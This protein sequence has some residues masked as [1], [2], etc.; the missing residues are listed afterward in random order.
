MRFKERSVDFGFGGGALLF[1]HSND[2]RL[3][4]S[5]TKRGVTLIL[6]HNGHEITPH[7]NALRISRQIPLFAEI[8]PPEYWN[9]TNRLMRFTEHS[10]D[11][12]FEGGPLLFQHSND[13]HANISQTKRGVTLILIHNRHVI[14][15]LLTRREFPNKPPI[16]QRYFLLN[17]ETIEIA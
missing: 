13:F 16:S 9:N 6:L 3:N 5:R 8:I 15:P 14:T 1:Q 17:I 10:L 12:I 11:F 2:C 4:I 7:F